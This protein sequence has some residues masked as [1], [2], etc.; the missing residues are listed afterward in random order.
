MARLVDFDSGL[1][2]DSVIVADH[3][4]TFTGQIDEPLLAHVLVKDM[5]LPAF[6]LESGTISFSK[7][8]APFGSML[9]DDARRTEARIIEIASAYRTAR[10]PEQAR[11]VEAAF[12]AAIDSAMTANADNPL[13]LYY[14][15]NGRGQNASAAEIREIFRK[16]PEIGRYK[17]SAAL[18]AIAEN[19]E[20]TQDGGKFID[21]K[22]DY[23]GTTKRLSDYVGRGK[24]TLVDFWASW[25]GPCMRQVPVLKEIQAKYK[26]QG[27]D[28][29]G[30]A[31]WD[32]PEATESAIVKHG[33]TWDN[34]IDAQNIPA[35]I[36]GIS[37][38]PC[39][40]LFGPD[41]TILSRGKQGDELRAAVD[42]AMAR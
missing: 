29:V 23:K 30:V 41:G 32:E 39:I 34:I 18:L 14:F 15:L 36:Y 33:I 38:I 7:D 1:T 5:R 25:C 11:A 42:Q 22:V 12:Y 28:V 19:R 2:I 8:Q 20:A 21:F 6:V 9:N 35:D 17:R 40:I 31:M 13:G 26:D 27:L 16:C 37:S 10:T 4:A 3:C 24:Y